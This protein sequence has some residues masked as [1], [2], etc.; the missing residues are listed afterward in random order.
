[1]QARREHLDL[2]VRKNRSHPLGVGGAT[3]ARGSAPRATI[4]RRHCTA[5]KI[6]PAGELRMIAARGTRRCRPGSPWR[7]WGAASGRSANDRGHNAWAAERRVREWRTGMTISDRA[8]A[9][10][11]SAGRASGA[12]CLCVG[13][14]ILAKTVTTEMGGGLPGGG[15]D[16]LHDSPLKGG[17]F[18]LPVPGHVKLCQTSILFVL[19]PGGG[20]CCTQRPP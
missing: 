1:L 2:G 17:G 12:G 19:L 4:T 3:R 16:G 13:V 7:R 8:E 5:N 9:G 15:T 20:G 18:E 6:R 10:E 14:V 11:G